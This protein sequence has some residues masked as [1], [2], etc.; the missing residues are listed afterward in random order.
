[1][2]LGDMLTGAQLNALVTDMKGQQKAGA[3]VPERLVKRHRGNK[4]PKR[5]YMTSDEAIARYEHDVFAWAEYGHAVFNA[6]LVARP[7]KKCSKPGNRNTCISAR[8]GKA[9]LTN[10]K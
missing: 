7:A 9:R 10:R 3:D 5:R 2:T 1:M 6:G 4:K 8:N